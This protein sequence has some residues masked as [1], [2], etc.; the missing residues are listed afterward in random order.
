MASDT[1]KKWKITYTPNT[2]SDAIEARV[3]SWTHYTQPA[4]Y[5]INDEAAY[6][7]SHTVAKLTLGL[8]QE[9]APEVSSPEA[10]DPAWGEVAP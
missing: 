4:M 1:P 5:Y 7:E 3:K 6:Y 9:K 2:D 10:V 8:G